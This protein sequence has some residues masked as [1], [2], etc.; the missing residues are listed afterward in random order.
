MAGVEGIEQAS[1][2]RLHQV[3]DLI[4]NVA[5]GGADVVGDRTYTGC[6]IS[7]HVFGL[8]IDTR[9]V[10]AEIA[11]GVLY[12]IARIL[13]VTLELLTGFF[14]GLRSVDESRGCTRRYP[15]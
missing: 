3:P 4:G 11:G 15:E 6:Y 1:E 9:G 2:R 7:G 5:G 13:Q 12:V 8:L 14:P 10:F